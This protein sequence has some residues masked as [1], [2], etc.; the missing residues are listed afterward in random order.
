MVVSPAN[1]LAVYTRRFAH[2]T[3]LAVLLQAMK[4]DP[5]ADAKCRDKFLVQAVPISGDKEFA[6]V[7]N[8]VSGP[9]LWANN[10]KLSVGRRVLIPCLL[11]SVG[12]GREIRYCGEENPSDFPASLLCHRRRSDTSQERH[13]RQRGMV[14]MS[15]FE[16]WAVSILT[17]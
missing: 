13:S 2:L 14:E 10:L 6:T 15:S 9:V 12:F 17:P 7:A 1:N 3:L 16:L 8:I 11:F 5:P 4:Q